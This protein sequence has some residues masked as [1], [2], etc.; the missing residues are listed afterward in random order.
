MTDSDQPTF[1]TGGGR[2][3]ALMRAHDWST[4]SL[5]HP[6]QWPQ[7][8]RT[9]VRIMLNTGHPMYVF[10]GPDL[11]C[12]YNDAY[13]ESI[14]PER[15]P[16]SLGQP[17]RQVWDEI[18]TIIGP[19]VDQVMS[20]RGATWNV[21]HL[22]PI[23]RHGRRENVY[24]TYSYSPI[25][26]DTSPSGVGGVLV[27]C[28][29][30]TDQVLT[31]RRLAAERDRLAQL[32]EQAPTFMTMLSGPDHRFEFVNPA[33]LQLVGHRSVVGRTVAE[34]L[35]EVVDQ[36]YIA[37]L[38]TV[39]HSGKA[40]TAT[41][42]RISLELEPGGPVCDRFVDFVYQPIK[43]DAGSVTGIFVLGA[44]VTDRLL[45]EVA[46]RESEAALR[47]ADKRKDEFLAVLAHELRNPLAPILTGLE[48]IRLSGDSPGTV[49]RVRATME[50]QVGHM[51][52]LIDDLLDVSRITAGKIELQRVPA[53]LHEL[54][55]GA[56]DANRSALSS[57]QINLKVDLPDDVVVLNV[58]VTRFVQTVSNLLHN[59]NKFTP[60]GGWVH[61]SA[62]V[63][64]SV[65]PPVISI[66]VADS[67]I[68]MSPELLPRVFE[69]FTQG[70]LASGEPGLGIGLALVRR[71]V[72]MHG[73]TVTARS[74]GPGHGSEFEILLPLAA[75]A[76]VP[77][78]AD[79]DTQRI[80]RRVVIIDDN[81]DAA[82]MMALLIE[83]LGGNARVAYDGDQGI[84]EVQAHGAEVVLLDI[85]MQP[86]DGYETCRRLRDLVGSDVVIVALTGWGQSQDKDKAEAAGFNAHLTKPADLAAL[87]ALL[88]SAPSD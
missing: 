56:V 62:R 70:R 61:L 78:P 66:R 1:L 11:S 88:A 14:G 17:A 45:G 72:E 28:T 15:H 22:V 53:K 60:A 23:T 71:L 18:W 29:E 80:H 7:S 54:I 31:A 76:A 24:W 36:G 2:M 9:A 87:R 33:Y 34:A 41:G 59:A 8:L 46:L 75:S 82:N 49:A 51:V 35:P 68:G 77:V 26:D 38:D 42:A 19:Q 13:S 74:D 81:T 12:L 63:V 65:E 39:R 30:T 10:W 5:G 73:G 86:L 84:R 64:P 55:Q 43:D 67:G 69:L 20:G 79:D 83:S 48:L 32:F 50:R 57:K 27:V 4:S 52:R 85:G 6:D 37:L 47:E 16:V 44:D 58:D 21:N 3:G 25:D 40:Y